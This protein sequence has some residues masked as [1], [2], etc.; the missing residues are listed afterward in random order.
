MEG[1]AYGLDRFTE[2]VGDARRGRDARHAALDFHLHLTGAILERYGCDDLAARTAAVH[3]AVRHAITCWRYVE[4]RRFFSALRDAGILQ[5]A[6]LEA[7]RVRHLAGER[8]AIITRRAILSAILALSIHARDRVLKREQNRRARRAVKRACFRHLLRAWHEARHTICQRRESCNFCSL[9]ASRHARAALVKFRQ[10]ARQRRTAAGALAA[11]EAMRDMSMKRRAWDLFLAAA[12]A[13]TQMGIAQTWGRDRATRPFYAALLC[14]SRRAAALRLTGRMLAVRRRDYAVARC[15]GEWRRRSA[16]R[17]ASRRL[18]DSLFHP[19]VRARQAELMDWWRRAAGRAL[20]R[21]TLLSAWV[22]HGLHRAALLAYR[23]W[24]VRAAAE[25]WT[26]VATE[27]AVIYFGARGARRL[28]REAVQAWARWAR[29]CFLI[30]LRSP[31]TAHARRS[32]RRWRTWVLRARMRAV[33]C[34]VLCAAAGAAALG[35]AISIWRS[36]A[37]RMAVTGARMG[38]GCRV[39]SAWAMSKAWGRLWRAAQHSRRLRRLKQLRERFWTRA[40]WVCLRSAAQRGCSCRRLAYLRRRL[41]TRFAMRWW[42]RE[43][44]LAR[45]VLPAGLVAGLHLREWRKTA[46]RG[47]ATQVV[48]AVIL[49]R[50]WAAW[51][52]GMTR[53][54]D[55]GQRRAVAAY[56]GR[57]VGACMVEWKGE[58]ARWRA[59]ACAGAWSRWRRGVLDAVARRRSSQL[60]LWCESCLRVIAQ[61]RKQALLLVRWRGEAAHRDRLTQEGRVRDSLALKNAMCAW[62]RLVLFRVRA[63]LF[64]GRSFLKRALD[65]WRRR[66]CDGHSLWRREKV[67]WAAV[68]RRRLCAAF[69][70][71]GTALRFRLT[72]FAFKQALRRQRLARAVAGLATATRRR[73]MWLAAN[74]VWRRGALAGALLLLR[75]RGRWRALCR[76]AETHAC[77]LLPPIGELARWRLFALRRCS[78]G[79][80]RANADRLHATQAGSLFIKRLAMQHARTRQAG[81]CIACCT[82]RALRRWRASLATPERLDG[83]S[84]CSGVCTG[85]VVTAQ[86]PSQRPSPL[87]STS[88]LSSPPSPSSHAGNADRPSYR[89][90]SQLGVFMVL[91]GCEEDRPSYR[92]SSQLGKTGAIGTVLSGCEGIGTAQAF[93][94]KQPTTRLSPLIVMGWRSGGGLPLPPSPVISDTRDAAASA[95]PRSHALNR[96]SRATGARA[97][98]KQNMF[99]AGRL[100]E[101][102]AC[103]RFLAGLRLRLFWARA[104][105]L[106]L[107]RRLR[108][109]LSRL[110]VRV[111]WARRLRLADQLARHSARLS[112]ARGWCG[113]VERWVEG[114][115]CQPAWLTVHLQEAIDPFLNSLAPGLSDDSRERTHTV[116]GLRSS[117][118]GDQLDLWKGSIPD[119]H[120]GNSEASLL[121]SA[122]SPLPSAASPPRLRIIMG[123]M[124]HL[125]RK[126]HLMTAWQRWCRVCGLGAV[127]GSI[128]GWGLQV[129]LVRALARLATW[130]SAAAAAAQISAAARARARRRRVRSAFKLWMGIAAAA[131]QLQVG[132]LPRGI[133]GTLHCYNRGLPV[134]VR[135]SMARWRRRAVRGRGDAAFTAV[136]L[137]WGGRVTRLRGMRALWFYKKTRA[138][139]LHSAM[140]LLAARCARAQRRATATLAAASG[141]TVGP[142]PVSLPVTHVLAARCARAQRG[143]VAAWAASSRRAFTV[144]E[145]KRRVTT[146]RCGRAQ[147]RFL[148]VWRLGAGPPA[149]GGEMV[150]LPM[151]EEVNG[152]AQREAVR[153]LAEGEDVILIYIG[154]E[155]T[156]LATGEERTPVA[157][158]KAV[159]LVAKEEEVT[160]LARGLA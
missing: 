28:V 47:M 46:R 5:A 150:P 45:G 153:L 48:R 16:R 59:A 108:Q 118:C 157:T 29:L 141:R 119:C 69:R 15:L 115:R 41:W 52:D 68:G 93:G 111:F 94:D 18:G 77:V 110:R 43:V 97:L 99:A 56:W 134:S 122:A 152:L 33:D 103:L 138:L 125:S 149:M 113:W 12:A 24:G 20:H 53:W 131:S 109:F 156:T 37:G 155:M 151:D 76:S 140:L 4:E 14:R 49:R 75:H 145:A 135:S 31:T 102:R 158:R 13:A 121:H 95:L 154:E 98:A 116:S 143:A 40:A 160:T 148:A 57:E 23:R 71:W 130:A 61:Q 67:A 70:A 34:A 126:H 62:R 88:L 100:C 21:Q 22:R 50:G 64:G 35:A 30:R 84:R 63:V 54:S 36:A 11:G 90:T 81:V 7:R 44:R 133:L 55:A 89:G 159:D 112:L 91:S 65:G 39:W 6:W 106:F 83:L 123:T 137:C 85:Q 17:A 147:A 79:R 32:L 124:H 25:A 27:E 104:P 86:Q 1:T 144:A 10:S 132:V 38:L 92:G 127:E 78:V 142:A 146:L 74:A 82:L 101:R 3:C 107:A 58:L 60:V 105:R 26:K 120:T 9:L 139:M 51:G 72:P 128:I 8:A 80:M 129:G 2:I 19:R 42:R 96:W 117:E 114:T 66:V 136:A 87:I 73:H